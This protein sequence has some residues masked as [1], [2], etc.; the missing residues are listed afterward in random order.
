V[1]LSGLQSAPEW[2]ALGGSV[3]NGAVCGG[4]VS[5]GAVAETSCSIGPC[6]TSKAR[7]SRACSAAAV[8]DIVPL[9]VEVAREVEVVVL[10]IAA[11][12]TCRRRRRHA[13]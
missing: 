12:S 8:S 3:A 7:L 2:T 1:A 4:A 6:S 13:P 9:V 10:S 11:V 5:G